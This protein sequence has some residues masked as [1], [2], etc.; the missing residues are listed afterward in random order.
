MLR[1]AHN[2]SGAIR[3][4]K[5]KAKRRVNT[6][7]D[8]WL[9]QMGAHPDQRKNKTKYKVKMPDYSCSKENIPPT[10]D[11]IGNGF[12][13]EENFYSGTEIIGIAT[14]HKSNLVPVLK[15]TNQAKEIAS[16]RR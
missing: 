3:K 13:K 4:S 7:H 8:A 9:R 2:S 14:M 10:S 6:A 11:V 5:R 15:D 1:Y 12:R 16:M